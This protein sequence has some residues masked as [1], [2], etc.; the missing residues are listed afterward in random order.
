MGKLAKLETLN[1]MN[2]VIAEIPASF[3]DM[4]NLKQ[5]MLSNNQITEFPVMFA[6]LKHLDSW[7]ITD[8][9]LFQLLKYQNL[10]SRLDLSRNKITKVPPEAK[11]LYCTELNLNQN[12][13][14]EISEQIAECTK[15]KTLRLE[16]NCL[17]IAAIPTKI[18]KESVIS[19]ITVDG[20]LFNSKQFTELEGYDEYMNRY[21]AVK[22]KMF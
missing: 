22:K 21:T 7:V 9:T 3:K 16:E 19:N 1:V 5:I 17:Q 18:L 13:I 20:N 12:Q 2:N 15:L 8:L 14:S 10:N 11:D 4:K 6:G